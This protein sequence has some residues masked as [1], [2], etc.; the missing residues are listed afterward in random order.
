MKQRV[1]L[2]VW[3][4]FGVGVGCVAQPQRCGGGHACAVAL[5]ANKGGAGAAGAS[6]GQPALVEPDTKVLSSTPAERAE[7]ALGVRFQKPQGQAI[8]AVVLSCGECVDVEA[9][10]YAGNPPFTIEWDNGSTQAVRSVC[11]DT[12]TTLSVRVTDT[13]LRTPEFSAEAQSVTAT[14]DT[15]VVACGDDGECKHGPGPQ[16]PASGRYAGSGTYVC[17]NDSNAQT[18]E[19]INHLQVTLDLDIDAST[20]RQQGHMFLQWGLVVI[21]GAGQ[22]SGA[23][24]CGG[25][26]RASLQNG[27]WGLPGNEPMS[28]IN[29][30]GLIGEFVA[31]ATSD[32]TTI[33]GSWTWTSMTA[34]GEYGN[35]CNGT[36]EAQ[37]VS[38]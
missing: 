4:G 35:T 30:G 32:P 2:A 12:P 28:L 19:L 16:T 27:T 10:A 36:Y 24:E 7:G 13:P 8:D 31:R 33:T 1:L 14:I 9:V 20:D 11:A 34:T 23:L 5:D 37:R 18:A 6:S 17:D 38:M 3:I 25:A 15:H 29:A 21:A 26:L 22:L